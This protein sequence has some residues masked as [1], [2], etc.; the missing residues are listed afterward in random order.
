MPTLLE[1]QEALCSSL[2]GRDNTAMADFVSV[3]SLLDTVNIYRNTVLVGLTKA[4]KLSFPVVLRLVGEDFFD[5]VALEF[6]RVAPPRAAYLDRYGD[7]FA[8]F[9]AGFPPAQSLPYLP[10][11]ARLE[12]AVNCALHAAD[13]DSLDLGQLSNIA[14][15]DRVCL[16][17]HPSVSLLNLAYPVDEIW[18]AIIENNDSALAQVDIDSG[19]VWLMIERRHSGVAVERMERTSWHLTRELLAGATIE[20]IA[21][22]LGELNLA[23]EIAA[24][25]AAA[26]IVAFSSAQKDDQD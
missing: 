22:P 9:L 4:L 25:L 23:A 7:A 13:S 15:D 14:S 26:R 1:M 2:L 6:I 24:H 17:F 19:P 20:S 11:M 5:V 18:R 10:D 21:G 8:A 3:E 12:W 16:K